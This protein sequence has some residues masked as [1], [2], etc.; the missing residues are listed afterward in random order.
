MQV[1]LLLPAIAIALLVSGACA[2]RRTPRTAPSGDGAAEPTTVVAAPPDAPASGNRPERE[3][4]GLASFYGQ[5]D[6]FHG[7]RTASG[8]IFDKNELVAAH[9][10][11]PF[12]TRVRVTNLANGRSVTLRV[13]DRGPTAE[14]VEEGVI[15]DVSARAARILGFVEEGRQRVRL[16]VLEW[17]GETNPD[18]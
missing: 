18:A 7:K 17:G 4:V 12:G 9:P 8:S 14:N 13:V 16:V 11:Y 3:V 10:S 5:G 15:I 1:R 2:T 6:G